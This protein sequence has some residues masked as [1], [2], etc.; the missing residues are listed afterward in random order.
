M[1]TVCAPL[2]LHIINRQPGKSELEQAIMPGRPGHALPSRLAPNPHPDLGG[3]TGPI[4]FKSRWSAS[5]ILSQQKPIS[6]RHAADVRRKTPAT[7]L[8]LLDWA[9]WP[10][11]RNDRPELRKAQPDYDLDRGMRRKCPRAVARRRSVRRKSRLVRCA[12]TAIVAMIA[13]RIMQNPR[14]I[15]GHQASASGSTFKRLVPGWAA[16]RSRMQPDDMIEDT[17]S[18]KAAIAQNAGEQ[19]F[20]GSNHAEEVF[21]SRAMSRRCGLFAS[22]ATGV[23]PA[24]HAI[25]DHV[26]TCR[27][28]IPA[29]L[30]PT[31]R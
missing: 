14:S 20:R 31:R 21:A 22:L 27:G 11:A 5:A 4:W 12:R 16:L 18:P 1:F 23:I 28:M 30:V 2:S 3:K 17:R 25:V 15:R 8:I 24:K 10:Q 6:P 9:N 19:L 26:A 29:A 7:A 13:Q